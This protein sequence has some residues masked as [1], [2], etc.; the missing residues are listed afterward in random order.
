MH[1]DL[2]LSLASA[3]TCACWILLIVAPRARATRW[4]LRSDAVPLVLCVVYTALIARY[5]PGIFLKFD[6]LEHI[7][8]MLEDRRLLLT[9]MLHFLAYDL[10][11]GRAMLADAQARGISH[12]RMV[13]CLVMSLLLA[14]VGYVMYAAVRWLSG[15]GAPRGATATAGS[16][17]A[18]IAG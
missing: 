16:T 13:P 9:S 7:H 2:A 1:L 3:A 8:E 10:L 18:S 5:I 4:V 6:S 14:P 17:G 12:A 15:P 11:V